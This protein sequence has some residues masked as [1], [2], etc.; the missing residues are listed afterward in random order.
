MCLCIDINMYEIQYDV[1]E[2]IKREKPSIYSILLISRRPSL[3][4][5]H[6]GLSPEGKTKTTRLCDIAMNVSLFM[7]FPTAFS[8]S[9]SLSP[10]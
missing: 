9:L 2:C 7:H 6:S 10:L 4:L 8:L 5:T 1:R 3:S